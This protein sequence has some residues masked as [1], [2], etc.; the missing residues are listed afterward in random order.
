M[1]ELKNNLD[2]ELSTVPVHELQ[3][4][5]SRESFYEI[6]DNHPMQI[7]LDA[8]SMIGKYKEITLFAKGKSI[9][10]AVT[11]ANI[12]TYSLL[13]GKCSVQKVKVDSEPILEMGSLQST[14]EIILKK[15]P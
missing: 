10:N 9:S 11:V 2:L 6:L 8:L 5:F 13:K 7:A 15:Y 14:I 4:T 1:K 12:L 3:N